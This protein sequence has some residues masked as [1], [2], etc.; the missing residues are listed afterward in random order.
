M[1]NGKKIFRNERKIEN[2]FECKIELKKKLTHSLNNN[3]KRKK[4]QSTTT[5][6]IKTWSNN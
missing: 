3:I 6:T 5:T 4:K 1:K 2:E